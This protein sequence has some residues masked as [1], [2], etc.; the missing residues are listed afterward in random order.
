MKCIRVARFA[1]LGLLLTGVLVGQTVDELID[2]NVKA[3]GGLEKIKAVKTIRMTGKMV[4]GEGMEMPIVLEIKR[5]KMTRMDFTFQGMTG[6]QAYDGKSGWSIMPFLGK[7]DPEPM[8][9]DDLKQAEDQA[10][11]D[12]PL[13]DYKTKGHQ[14]ELMGKEKVEGT[15]AYK[16]KVTKKSGDVTYLYLDSEYFLEIKAE[17]KRKIQGNEAEIESS[18]GDYK[19]VEG[20]MMPHSIDAGVKGAPQRQKIVVSKIELNVPVAD[21]RF[22]MPEV[23]KAPTPPKA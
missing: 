8:S 23:K 12:G 10:D 9:A 7:K 14:V 6:T 21:E 2:K 18:I 3:R 4:M 20:L 11:I 16:L 17:S 22:R 1:G 15:D 5:P 13:I 19:E